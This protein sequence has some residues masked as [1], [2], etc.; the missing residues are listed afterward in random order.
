MNWRA[1]T[2]LFRQFVPFLFI[3]SS[4]GGLGMGWTCWIFQD[5]SPMGNIFA[6]GPALPFSIGLRLHYNRT[7]RVT[8]LYPMIL[9][10]GNGQGF[11]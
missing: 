8:L 6:N 7:G 11:P 3:F 4:H 10:W 5:P 9:P 1:Q 2:D